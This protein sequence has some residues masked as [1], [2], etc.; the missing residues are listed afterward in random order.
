MAEDINQTPQKDSDA[1][2]AETVLDLQRLDKDDAEV[3][4]HSCCSVLSTS[5]V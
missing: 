5:E 4:A 1:E 3:Q 2:Q